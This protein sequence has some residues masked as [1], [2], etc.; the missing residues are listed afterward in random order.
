[1]L[2]FLVVERVVTLSTFLVRLLLLL[3]EVLVV[4]EV[5]GAGALALPGDLGHRLAEVDVDAAVVDE[6][7]VH[8]EVG[9][10]TVLLALELDERVAQRVTRL[11]VAYHLAAVDLAEAREDQLEVVVVRHR[12]Q[13]AH[14]QHVLRRLDIYI[15][16]RTRI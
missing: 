1:M 4:V 15:D 3:F 11:L 12:I 10:L 2:L 9:V 8:L 7:V 6:H 13:L 16:E 14:K 5:A